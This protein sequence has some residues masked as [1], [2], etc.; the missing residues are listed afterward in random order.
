M[1]LVGPCALA[2]GTSTVVV[3]GLDGVATEAVV[4]GRKPAAQ[5]KVEVRCRL[6]AALVHMSV[7]AG[8]ASGGCQ[9]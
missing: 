2:L 6:A 9:G 1:L 5:D 7:A 4:A 8:P 3:A